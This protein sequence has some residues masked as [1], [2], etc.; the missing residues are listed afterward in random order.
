M[1]K[2]SKQKWPTFCIVAYISY[3]G[4]QFCQKKKKMPNSSSFDQDLYNRLKVDISTHKILLET[5]SENIQQSAEAILKQKIIISSKEGILF[6]CRSFIDVVS[7]FPKNI[8]H[9]IEL[10]ITIQNSKLTDK[11]NFLYLLPYYITRCIHNREILRLSALYFLRELL[12]RN[13]ISYNSII[14]EFNN[15]PPQFQSI[16]TKIELI[17]RDGQC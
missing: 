16:N 15:L 1:H 8:D 2:Y 14:N 7:F 4:L 12:H 11:D 9:L 10:F 5:T 6:L 3:S 17:H 13:S